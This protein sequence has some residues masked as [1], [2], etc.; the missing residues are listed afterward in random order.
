M[1]F[2][3]S[4]QDTERGEKMTFLYLEHC[5]AEVNVNVEEKQFCR[6]G[7]QLLTNLPTEIKD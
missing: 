3:S 1:I 2:E 4:N 6:R 5:D 7:S